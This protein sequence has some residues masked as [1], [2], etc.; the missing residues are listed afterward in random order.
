MLKMDRAGTKPKNLSSVIPPG[1]IVMAAK[2]F[3]DAALLHPLWKVVFLL[4]HYKNTTA[5]GAGG[6]LPQFDAS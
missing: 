5:G 4:P 2:K 6:L 1:G 3:T